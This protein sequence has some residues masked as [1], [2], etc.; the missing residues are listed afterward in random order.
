MLQAEEISREYNVLDKLDTNN[1]LQ[2]YKRGRRRLFLLDYDG[3][4]MPY[5]VRKDFAC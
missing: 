3:T 1:F 4:L 5:Q 2:F